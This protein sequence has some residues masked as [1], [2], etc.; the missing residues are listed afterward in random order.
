MRRRCRHWLDPDNPSDATLIYQWQQLYE[1]AVRANNPGLAVKP[2]VLTTR[3][4]KWLHRRRKHGLGCMGETYLQSRPDDV[5]WLMSRGYT[6]IDVSHGPVA[7]RDLI[8]DTIFEWWE[9]RE[10]AERA[11]RAAW[12]TYVRDEADEG[13][14]A[15][16]WANLAERLWRPFRP[17]PAPLQRIVLPQPMASDSTAA[18][19]TLYRFYAADGSLLYI[20]KTTQSYHQRIRGHQAKEWYPEAAN[21]ALEQVPAQQ[22]MRLEA[23]A[24]RKEKPRYNI[25]HNQR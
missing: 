25:V 17:R 8:D 2:N 15:E 22:V 4:H 5:D 12:V 14:W 18:T 9:E 24:I 3:P 16:V 20:G 11:A 10:A 19:A 21:I 7:V 23:E 1:S 6:G 13:F